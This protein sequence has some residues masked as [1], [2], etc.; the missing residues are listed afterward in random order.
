MNTSK[1]AKAFAI[2]YKGTLCSDD[3]EVNNDIFI[4]DC[5]FP[6]L[7]KGWRNQADYEEGD[8]SV[9][10][11][12]LYG[13]S[14][15]TK[16]MFYS[17]IAFI[18][19]CF[20]LHYLNI[21]QKNRIAKG[22]PTST[23][24]STSSLLTFRLGS[25]S[26]NLMEKLF[27]LNALFTVV[28]TI[29][30]IDIDSVSGIIGIIPHAALVGIGIACVCTVLCLLVGTWV[31]ILSSKGKVQTQP[32]WLKK[33]T[34]VSFFVFYIGEAV[35]GCVEYIPGLLPAPAQIN[36]YG[37]FSGTCNAVKVSQQQRACSCGSPNTSQTQ[38]HINTDT[39]HYAERAHG[40]YALVLDGGRTEVWPRRHF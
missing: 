25:K 14:Y 17:L 10:Y 22:E 33:A 7:N 18:P 5:P 20:S 35:F 11:K 13:S 29:S 9:Q 15:T 2:D 34:K 8:C 37:S 12:D 32:D 3:F 38:T 27:G 23:S 31:T 1:W 16:C 4:R 24:T 30:G 26:I 6:T 40:R 21:V 36:S 19:F 39:L 28:L